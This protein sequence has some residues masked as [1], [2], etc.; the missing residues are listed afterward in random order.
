MDPCGPTKPM[1]YDG[2]IFGN[3]TSKN[4][5]LP[6]EPDLDCQWH[7]HVDDGYVIQLTF[8][9]FDVENE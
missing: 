7:I 8:P 1:F 2:V 5:P 6:Y 3:I 9:E 4:Y